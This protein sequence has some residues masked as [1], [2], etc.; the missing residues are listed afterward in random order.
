MSYHTQRPPTAMLHPGVID[1]KLYSKCLRVF[2][3]TV[4]FSVT[5]LLFKLTC[6]KLLVINFTSQ[7]IAAIT[8]CVHSE[9]LL[10]SS[11]FR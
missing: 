11:S 9:C 8:R 10:H 2:Y 6:S 5:C 3:S 1:Y 7:S 4:T